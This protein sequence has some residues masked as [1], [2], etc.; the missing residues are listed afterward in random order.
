MPK[1]SA[2]KAHTGKNYIILH[3]WIT[4]TLFE[5]VVKCFRLKRVLNLKKYFSGTNNF[6]K[7]RFKLHSKLPRWQSTIYYI[8]K[9]RLVIVQYNSKHGSALPSACVINSH[10]W[11]VMSDFEWLLNVHNLPHSKI[12]LRVISNMPTRLMKTKCKLGTILQVW[13]RIQIKNSWQDPWFQF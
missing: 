1:P 11:S 2:D 13:Q 3:S 7:S 6:V 12:L 8:R 5:W 4:I 9:I 10:F